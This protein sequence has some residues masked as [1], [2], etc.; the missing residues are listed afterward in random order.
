MPPR[1]TGS[2]SWCAI[3]FRQRFSSDRISRRWTFRVSFASTFAQ[4]PAHIRSVYDL[5]RNGVR[6][7]IGDRS[8][9]V[10]AYTRRLLDA[11]GITAGVMRNVVSQETDVK[12]I[13][14]KVALGEADA[15]FV[16]RTDARSAR[17][18]ITPLGVPAW[19]QP[20]IRYEIALVRSS[21]H[22]AAAR[23]FIRR[24]EAARGRRIL[25]AGGFGVPKR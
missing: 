25:A 13:V 16:Y 2:K 7:V 6:V 22:R 17:G 11:L 5:R 19:A 14:A 23:A 24:V 18:K 8:V 1:R 12:G 3:A 9:P 10:G 15:G 4:N 21:S 20:P